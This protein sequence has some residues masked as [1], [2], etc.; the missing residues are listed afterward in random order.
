[1]SPMPK[2]KFSRGRLR[3]SATV[4]NVWGM[5]AVRDGA[6]CRTS[7]GENRVMAAGRAGSVQLGHE[8]FITKLA[9]RSGLEGAWR[10]GEIGRHGV[11]CDIDVARSMDRDAIAVV[12][13]A[14]A[15]VGGVEKRRAG[16]VQLAH[17]GVVA[18]ARGGLEGAWRGGKVVLGLTCDIGV[19]R[20]VHRDGRA[21][22]SAPA[23]VGGVEQGRASGVQLGHEGIF[24]PAESGLEGP[25]GCGEIDGRGRACHIGVTRDIRRD[26]RATVVVTPDR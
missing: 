17:E 20:G 15:Q 25:W 8:G 16:G 23:Q 24:V 26:A 9:E 6:S 12:A 18:A 3:T 7:P 1:M 4:W 14:S 5:R 22:A 2:T 19:A 11:A 13:T 21:P 10:G